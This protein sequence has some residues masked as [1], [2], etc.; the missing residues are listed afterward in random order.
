MEFL[1]IF[2]KWKVFILTSVIAAMAVSSVLVYFVLK[3]IYSGSCSILPPVSGANYLL[4]GEE[5]KALVEGDSFLIGVS[6]KAGVS[7]SDLKSRLV[8]RTP[9]K[10]NVIRIVFENPDRGKISKVLYEILDIL[11]E[12]DG[13]YEAYMEGLRNQL[14]TYNK[15]IARTSVKLLEIEDELAKFNESEKD[16]TAYIMEH[17]FLL[18][19]YSV[20]SERLATLYEQSTSIENTITLTKDFTFV[21]PPAISERPVRPRKLLDI[22]LTGIFALIASLIFILGYEYYK[23]S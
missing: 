20:I 5:V 7:F 19:S 21:N 1:R 22:L 15:E 2:V 11:K 17:S 18:S 16:K 12:R 13:K 23:K 14:S 8:V 3:P 6:Q 4:S 10:T 9:T